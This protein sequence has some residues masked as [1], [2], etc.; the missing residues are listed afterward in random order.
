MRV[1]PIE[2]VRRHRFTRERRE[3]LLFGSRSVPFRCGAFAFLSA[4][5]PPPSHQAFVAAHAEDA[6]A[7][8]RVPQVL[9]L[10]FAVPAAEACCAE[11]LFASENREVFD[12]LPAGV[13]RVGAVV[14]DEGAVAEEE[15]VRVAVE[16]E[17]AGVAAETVDVPSVACQFECLA[18]FQNLFEERQSAS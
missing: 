12:L 15:E 17:T 7:R 4:L 18:F 9:D 16:E 11:R 10:A 14:A 2:L 6:L 3:A 13:A 1:R 5:L 8:A